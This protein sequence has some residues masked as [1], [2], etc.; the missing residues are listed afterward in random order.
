M[1][2]LLTALAA[3]VLLVLGPVSA[4]AQETDT[5]T[6]TT[7]ATESDN[8]DMGLWG[9]LGLTGLLGLAG[10]M[11]RDRREDYRYDDRTAEPGSE[12][13]IRRTA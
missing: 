9:L 1:R 7:T 13:Q 11:R 5:G 8:G 2:K 6:E 4:T 10:L 3:T 12:T